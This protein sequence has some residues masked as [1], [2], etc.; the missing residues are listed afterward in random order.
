MF[1]FHRDLTGLTQANLSVI[2]YFARASLLA[3]S[4]PLFAKGGAAEFLS[5]LPLVSEVYLPV[6]WDRRTQRIN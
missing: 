3:P 4:L 5:G 2:F 1:G 6:L